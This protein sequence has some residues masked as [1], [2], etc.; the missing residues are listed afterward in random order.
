M[1][2]ATDEIEKVFQ[3][4]RRTGPSREAFPGVGLGLSVSRRIV[5]AHR[6]RLEVESALGVG[7]TF[8]VRLPAAEEAPR[9]PRAG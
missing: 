2:I 5:E 9:E 7:S 1:G 4:F 3:P 6:G 8:C